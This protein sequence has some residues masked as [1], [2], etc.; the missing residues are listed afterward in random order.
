MA[1][2]SRATTSTSWRDNQLLL[3]APDDE[4][5]E[6][7]QRATGVSAEKKRKAVP[8]GCDGSPAAPRAA[9]A[10]ARPP[11]GGL[12][13]RGGEAA[14]Q[15]WEVARERA[16]YSL[17][18][19]AVNGM[20]CS[21]EDFARKHALRA[22]EAAGAWWLPT[23]ADAEAAP[24]PKKGDGNAWRAEWR[25]MRRDQLD[26][27]EQSE[28][29]GADE[30]TTA[31][32]PD[33][34]EWAIRSF[35]PQINAM[36][37]EEW[38]RGLA[39]A[40][41]LIS[42][43]GAA[44]LARARRDGS[45]KYKNSESLVVGVLHE[46]GAQMTAAAPRCFA[47]LSGMLGLAEADPAWRALFSAKPNAAGAAASSASGG[48]DYGVEP[49][50]TSA[51]VIAIDSPRCLPEAGTTPYHAHLSRGGVKE[52]AAPFSR[53]RSLP[54]P[55]THRPPLTP[56]LPRRR[57]AAVDSDVVAFESS[58]VDGTGPCRSLVHMGGM[59][60]HL[61]PGATVSLVSVEDKFKAYGQ[62]MKRRL[63][64]VRVEFPIVAPTGAAA[65]RSA[66]AVPPPCA[67]AAMTPL[68]AAAGRTR[69]DGPGSL[70]PTA[71]TSRTRS[72]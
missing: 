16:D 24:A 67:P 35:S 70:G 5:A 25:E 18:R 12:G 3:D 15:H 10:C 17:T 46:R 54:T 55:P 52:C 47:H 50:T 33:S 23:G 60:Y 38:P 21:E 4:P 68:G 42:C 11:P 6:L 19:A 32:R 51:L 30:R 65:A 63:Y 28:L 49:F 14:R 27:Q 26:L 58:F 69:G 9:A 20:Q 8:C 31:G 72:G 71:Q 41:T 61:P 2:T 1:S 44:A 66:G 36:V 45:E 62:A 56:R 7:G 37:R 48:G 34:L 43:C 40:Y 22:E 57:W 39:E 13:E 29:A 53:S 59:G 64:T